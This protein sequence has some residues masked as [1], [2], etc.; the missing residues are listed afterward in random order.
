MFTHRK[1]IPTNAPTAIAVA[2][3]LASSLIVQNPFHQ[4]SRRG[5]RSQQ[6]HA[7]TGRS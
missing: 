2:A 1:R 3:L 7:R 5:N 4:R 6:Q